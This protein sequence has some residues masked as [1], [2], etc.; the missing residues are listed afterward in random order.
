MSESNRVIV[1]GNLATAHRTIT[2][3]LG[4]MEAF[5]ITKP[6]SQEMIQNA[7]LPAHAFDDPSF[8]ISAN[9]HLELI[10]AI[11]SEQTS[12]ESVITFVFLLAANLKIE[13][14]G[15]V[16]LIMKFSESFQEA[17]R[18]ALA[19]PEL[20]WGHS[21]IVIS[22]GPSE[23]TATFTM[24]RP[25]LAGISPE[26]IDRL[27]CFC[28]VLDM[29]TASVEFIS[30]VG[31]AYA[32][33]RMTLPFSEPSDWS[34]AKQYAPCP[35]EFD[36]EATQVFFPL[37]IDKAIPIHANSLSRRN[38]EAIAQKLS[39]MLSEGTNHTERVS[40]WLWAYTPPLSRTDIATQLAMSERSLARKLKNEGTS[41]KALYNHVQ[42][43][44][45]KNLLSNESLSIAEI[46][47][48]LGYSEA[49]VFTRAFTAQTEMAPLK[50]R[51]VNM[52]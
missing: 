20:N 33:T 27:R 26:K 17:V 22:E 5:G 13:D 7:G 3:A 40:R 36:A 46:A 44:R 10:N 1:S 29:V 35:V 42:T 15:V 45:A 6:K 52:K 14:F 4:L 38:F 2:G 48:R 12:G 47:D 32:P 28:L 43:E 11:L 23:F 50:W 51:K 9:Q 39:S 49:A 34:S 31:E 16:G 25:K 18:A 41:Y 37:S 30:I 19:Y 24:E 8:P 21:R